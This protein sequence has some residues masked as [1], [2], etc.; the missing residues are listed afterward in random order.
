MDIDDGYI[1]WTGIWKGTSH[2]LSRP[3]VLIAALSAWELQRS[4]PPRNI[5]SLPH[6]ALF[7]RHR[8]NDRFTARLGSRHPS[9]T[10]RLS[11]NTGNLDALRG[12]RPPFL[13]VHSAPSSRSL[14][15]P[16]A[17]HDGMYLI[18]FSPFASQFTRSSVAWPIRDDLVPL[19]G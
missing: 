9:G 6:L 15:S 5:L 13:A 18:H 14:R 3:P 2:P 1:L 8:Q 10:R 12:K 11:Q 16:F 7:S 4:V 19:F 17:C